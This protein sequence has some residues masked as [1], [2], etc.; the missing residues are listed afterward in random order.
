MLAQQQRIRDECLGHGVAFVCVCLCVNPLQVVAPSLPWRPAASDDRSMSRLVPNMSF[1][2]GVCAFFREL[3]SWKVE[4]PLR[5]ANTPGVRQSD[6]MCRLFFSGVISPV[7]LLCGLWTVFVSFF[8]PSFYPT[9]CRVM[10]G[11]VLLQF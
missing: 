1:V 11:H 10:M 4:H 9:D 3:F 5:C 2:M 8:F 7:R 6:R